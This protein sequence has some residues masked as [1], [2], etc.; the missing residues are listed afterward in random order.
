MK[1]TLSKD[2]TDSNRRGRT[3]REWQSGPDPRAAG[4]SKRDMG[5]SEKDAKSSAFQPTGKQMDTLLGAQRL[6][7]FSLVLKICL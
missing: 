5:V 2:I 1:H 4:K 7:H 6:S 3:I